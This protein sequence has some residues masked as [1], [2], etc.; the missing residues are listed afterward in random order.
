MLVNLKK[1]RK[2]IMLNIEMAHTAN[3]KK[4][5]KLRTL[6]KNC[7]SLFV[8][9]HA[10]YVFMRITYSCEL[11][12]HALHLGAQIC[13]TGVTMLKKQKYKWYECQENVEE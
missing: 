1:A 11:R 9:P 5:I 12:I 4:K 10:N 8:R 6:R 2:E 3:D 13:K 7:L